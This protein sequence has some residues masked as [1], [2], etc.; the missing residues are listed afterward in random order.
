M[1]KGT[2]VVWSDDM[3]IHNAIV[4]TQVCVD[5]FLLKPVGKICQLSINLQN[6]ESQQK[7]YHLI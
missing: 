1:K 7:I 3:R 6:T 2:Y 5:A 4:E